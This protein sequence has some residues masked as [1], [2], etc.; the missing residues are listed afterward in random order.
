MKKKKNKK[1][2]R[3]SDLSLHFLNTFIILVEKPVSLTE[4]L[5][6]ISSRVL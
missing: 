2:W 4:M 5:D 6:A 3:S 1:L